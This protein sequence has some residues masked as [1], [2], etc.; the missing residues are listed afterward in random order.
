[1]TDHHPDGKLKRTA[2][3]LFYGRSLGPL[4]G[5]WIAC[6]LIGTGIFI[7]ETKM[8][9]FHEVV[10]IIYFILLVILVIATGRWFRV[11]GTR[12]KNA[13]RR[14]AERRHGKEDR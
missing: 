1:M 9:V 13:D 4:L 14:H 2:K 3:K 11:R 10:K 7:L 6:I 8:P 5:P 12:R